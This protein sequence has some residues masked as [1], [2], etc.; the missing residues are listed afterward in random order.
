M[1]GMESGYGN[2]RYAQTPLELLK[3]KK[4]TFADKVIY[5]VAKSY[6][7]ISTGGSGTF[8]KDALI[9]RIAEESGA[10]DRQV[11]ATMKK[12]VALGLASRE[13]DEKKQGRPYVY[14]FHNLPAEFTGDKPVRLPENLPK[15]NDGKSEERQAKVANQPQ[16]AREP[17]QLEHWA[18]SDYR[19]ITGGH[20]PNQKL[21]EAIVSTVTDRARWQGVLQYCKGKGYKVF[22]SLEL[23]RAYSEGWGM[24]EVKPKVE[25]TGGTY[26]TLNDDWERRLRKS[27]RVT[28]TKEEGKSSDKGT[29]KAEPLA[30]RPL[31]VQVNGNR[32]VSNYDDDNT[33][34]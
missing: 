16:P 3:S 8:D 12:L 10:G 31:A 19:E 30:L 28:Q 21:Q 9:K 17:N 27:Q 11:K 13:R 7:H 4:L 15:K 26:I 18:L 14:R 33:I 5:Q 23:V 22:Q 1:E 20:K 32:R 2:E 34:Y 24:E 25:K 6:D 29:G